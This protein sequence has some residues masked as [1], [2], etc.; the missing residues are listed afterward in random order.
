MRDRWNANA[1]ASIAATCRYPSPACSAAY[2]KLLLSFVQM[3]L[4]RRQGT[5]RPCVFCGATHFSTSIIDTIRCGC[6][7]PALSHL[8]TYAWMHGSPPSV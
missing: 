4:R 2:V 7:R 1:V 3:P 5:S 6:F 8:R